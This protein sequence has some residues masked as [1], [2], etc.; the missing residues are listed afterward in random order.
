[1]GVIRTERLRSDRVRATVPGLF[2][3]RWM[4]IDQRGVCIAGSEPPTS[5]LG[6]A[7]IGAARET[8]TSRKET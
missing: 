2:W 1:M 4:M 8:L 7:L 5:S 6:R 3:R